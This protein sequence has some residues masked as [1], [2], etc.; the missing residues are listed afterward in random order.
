MNSPHTFFHEAPALVGQKP[1]KDFPEVA[2]VIPIHE[3]GNNQIKILVFTD[4]SKAVLKSYFHH[5]KDQ[6]DRLQHEFSFLL[7][8]QKNGIS[9]VP[10]PLW[11][12][13]EKKC[14]LYTYISGKKIPREEVT[15]TH[16]KAY[17][18]FIKELNHPPLPKLPFASESCRNLLEYF[19][20]AEMK[21]KRL[22]ISSPTSDLLTEFEKWRSQ[23]LEP[24]FETCR[25]LALLKIAKCQKSDRS[26]LIVSP[27]DVGFHNVLKNEKLFFIDFEYAG[28][29]DPVKTAADL[30]LNPYTLN[31]RKHKEEILQLFSSFVD[32]PSSFKQRFEE[33]FILNHLKWIGI[34]LNVFSRVGKLRRSFAQQTDESHLLRQW[35][36][37]KTLLEDLKTTINQL[38]EH[39]V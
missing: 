36:L 18:D 6:R 2:E 26:Q 29:D 19:S 13:S 22:Q 28:L 12:D 37:A 24:C 34:V 9:S 21:I 38:E 35:N 30:I 16:A 7:Y 1:W 39:Y 32:A 11:K 17:I 27:S 23:E 8:C 33:V 3:G 25:S 15:L 31:L 10:I 20:I 14:A 4:A 5:P